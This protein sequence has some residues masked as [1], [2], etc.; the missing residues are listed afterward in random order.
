VA[1]LAGCDGASIGRSLSE[2]RGLPH[3]LEPVATIGGVLWVNDSKAT[4]VAATLVA[5]QAFERPIVLILG[6]RHKGEPFVPLIPWLEHSAGVVAFGEA[7]PQVVA[8]LNGSVPAIHVEG[9]L[10]SA[11]RAASVLARP[12]DVVL[13]SP[14]CSSFDMFRNYEERGREYRRVVEALERAGGAE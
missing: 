4:N 10:E 12:G 2:F 1:A 5:V 7:A 14:A 13:F 11:V 6:G 3:R 9:S 8:E